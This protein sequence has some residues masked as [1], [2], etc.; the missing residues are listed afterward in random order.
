MKDARPIYEKHPD[1]HKCAS[2]G[3]A[4]AKKAVR[5][6]NIVPS[7]SYVLD[8][9]QEA[10]AEHARGL[11]HGGDRVCVRLEG[12][13][14]EMTAAMIREANVDIMDKLPSQVRTDYYLVKS[15]EIV[16]AMTALAGG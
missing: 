13:K 14:L 5:Q 11:R 12:A 16:E 8:L 4:R 3:A 6:M 9:L 10:L 2:P 15:A 1:F 7:D